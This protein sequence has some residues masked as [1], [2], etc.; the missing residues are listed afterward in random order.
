MTSHPFIKFPPD[1][2]EFPAHVWLLLGEI[3]ARIDQIKR[4]PIPREN[5][6]SLRLVYLTKGVH[7]TTAI[8]GNSFS[9]DEVAKIIEGK[10][11]AQPSREYQQ[12]QIDN[13]LHAFNAVAD[14]RLRGSNSPF[15]MDLLNSYHKIVLHNLEESLASEVV[16]GALR[17]HRVMAGRY[18]A[19]PPEECARLIKLYCDWLNQ[20]TQATAGYEIAS[21]IIKALVAH[22]YFAWIHPYGDG[23]GRMTR[24]IEFMILLRAGVPDVAAHL[25]SN[26]YN[27]TRDQYYMRLQASHGEYRDGSYPENSNLQGFIRYALQGFKDELDEQFSTIHS[28]QVRIIWHDYIHVEFR[29]RFSEKLS[30]ARQRQK[31][32]I[33][34]LT[35]HKFDEPVTKE[36]I[37]D[38]SPALYYAY[39]ERNKRM[40]QRD[41]NALL[42]MELLLHDGTGY[43]QNSDIL[44]GFFANARVEPGQRTS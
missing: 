14:T 40:I 21:Q 35:D 18:L 11:Q 19:A 42:D 27:K 37:R 12:Q 41:L 28:M 6:D 32:L 33:L 31:R 10:L 43:K 20:D 38:V 9:E 26:F 29:K 4:I 39:A 7:S 30:A 1:L 25:L 24:L 23:N 8:E 36:Q 22:V 5:S 34:D 17:R 15:T 13:M 2:G 16:I 3:Q 44:L